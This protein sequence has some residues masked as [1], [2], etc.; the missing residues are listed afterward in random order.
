[1][2]IRLQKIARRCRPGEG[3]TADH[4]LQREPARIFQNIPGAKMVALA[5]V[6]VQGSRR[7]VSSTV[8]L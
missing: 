1:M 7:N 5:A 4:A 6:E 2:I 3:L 8:A